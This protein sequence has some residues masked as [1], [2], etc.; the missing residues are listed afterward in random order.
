MPI[1]EAQR[2]SNKKVKARLYAERK[3]AGTCTHCGK[4]PAAGFTHC[5]ALLKSIAASKARLRAERVNAGLC[6]KCGGYKLPRFVSC[7]ECREKDAGRQ[8]ARKGRI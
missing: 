7:V 3:A 1:S 2:K 6:A 8:R 5:Q 4:A